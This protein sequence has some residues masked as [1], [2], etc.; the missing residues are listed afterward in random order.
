MVIVS[1]WETAG[2]A[3]HVVGELHALGV[4][5]ILSWLILGL[6]V[7]VIS[8]CFSQPWYEKK[9]TFCMGLLVSTV[10]V[11]PLPDTNERSAPTFASWEPPHPITSH[12]SASAAGSQPTDCSKACLLTDCVE[13]RE[14]HVFT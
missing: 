14:D 11:A 9:P 2:W 13:L 1:S 6:T 10:P 3:A 7:L 5:K 4:M 12:R 8:P